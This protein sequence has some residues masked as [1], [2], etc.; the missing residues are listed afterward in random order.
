MISF[1]PNYQTNFGTRK[2]FKK[3]FKTCAYSGENFEPRNTKTLEHIIP[4]IRGGKE[5]PN[6]IVVKRS[7]NG[8][9]SAEGLDE[10]IKKHP[11][12]EENIRKTVTSLEGKIIDGINW[13]KE[14]KKTLLE[15]I[16]RDIFKT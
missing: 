10:F 14:V 1:I 11:Q 16:G 12:V 15:E 6:L 9:R 8:L 7:W 2:K 4:E 5:L 3:M 13:A